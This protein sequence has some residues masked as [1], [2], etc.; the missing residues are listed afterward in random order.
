MSGSARGIHAQMAWGPSAFGMTR[1]M[2]PDPRVVLYS[3][4]VHAPK[5]RER[6]PHPTAQLLQTHNES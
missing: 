5:Q 3:V 4:Y 6:V 2:R 1:R